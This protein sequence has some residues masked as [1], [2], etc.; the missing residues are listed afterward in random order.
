M[1]AAFADYRLRKAS[2]ETALNLICPAKIIMSYISCH[3]TSKNKANV[4]AHNHQ[5]PESVTVHRIISITTRTLRFTVT[6][7]IAWK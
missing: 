4:H 1:Y 5:R 6:L 3:H 7:I 2:S